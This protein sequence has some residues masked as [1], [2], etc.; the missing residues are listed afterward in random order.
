MNIKKNLF[1]FL[2]LFFHL[3]ISLQPNR[4]I[5]PETLLKKR[6]G[7][8]FEMA[9][10]LCSLLIGNRYA[11]MVVSG[12]A[13]REVTKNDQQRIIC[14]NIPCSTAE[15]LLKVIHFSFV[16]V[17]RFFHSFIDEFCGKTKNNM[18]VEK[19]KF[20]EFCSLSF[21]TWQEPEN[22]KQPTKTKTKYTLPEPIDLQSKFLQECEERK[23]QKLAE[24]QQ[25]Q[26]IRRLEGLK[27]LE[28]LPDDEH[29]GNR[30]HA[31]IVILSN[32]EWAA[33]KSAGAEHI[34]DESSND[35]QPFFIEPSTGSYF[36]IEDANYFAIESVWNE[37]NYYVNIFRC[38]FRNWC[39][40]V[41]FDEQYVYMFGFCSFFLF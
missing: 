26:N 5:S 32:V 28:K 27:I 8:V 12:Y 1:V 34:I 40:N 30:R 16:F 22:D 11:A 38:L 18:L 25:E 33:K 2:F 23:H 35:I 21:F 9:T 20:K 39:K 36:P 15:T 7:N 13:S 24:W 10:L 19:K 37:S 41:L 29:Y 17:L 3:S 31:W 14:P 6:S 4:L